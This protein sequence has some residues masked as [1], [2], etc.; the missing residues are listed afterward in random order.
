MRREGIP[1][2]K[3]PGEKG[4]ASS[5][6]PGSDGDD[7]PRPILVISRC[8]G[9][10][11]C[12]WNGEVARDP[13]VEVLVPHIRAITVCPEVDM[14]L[15]VPREPVHLEVWDSGIRLVQFGP[16][17]DHTEGM[18]AFCRKFLKGLKEVDGFLLKARSPS[19][20]NRDVKVYPRGSD[21]R[22][23]IG[24]SAGI[25]AAEVMKSFPG[26]PVESEGRLRNHRI[27]E[28][29][30][31]RI[32]LY[33]RFREAMAVGTRGSLVEFHSRHKLILMAY[34][35]GELREMGRL[36]ARAADH[37]TTE[38][39]R[40]YREH[41]LR[42]TQRLPRR[43]SHLNVLLH[44]MGYFSKGLSPR[45]KA[46]FLSLLEAFREEKLPL[47]APLAVINSWIARFGQEYLESQHYFQPYPEELVI[48]D[49]SGKG[50]DL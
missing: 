9:F 12:R 6:G 35:Q 4:L 36:L 21:D 25:F 48:L 5:P 50:R 45:E 13:F 14:G 34:H 23:A 16:G 10:E 46:H 44:A 31:T 17:I 11:A 27:R 40:L 8:L 41:L 30:L 3:T 2:S 26:L 38:L 7:H 29:F 18:L 15:G 24:K 47:S 37:P 49:D 28:H 39:F 1:G 19:C 33:A 32:F 20:G 42:A 43:T 22:G